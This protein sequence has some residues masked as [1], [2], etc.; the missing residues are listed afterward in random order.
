MNGSNCM[1]RIVAGFLARPVGVINLLIIATGCCSVLIFAMLGLKTVAG[2]VVFSIIYGL[3]AGTCMFNLL[4]Y[5]QF[6]KH[7][8]S[9]HAHGTSCSCTYRRCIRTGV[10]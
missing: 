1:A 10:R 2:L 4:H 7:L 9:Y 6:S 8:S 5:A 3:F